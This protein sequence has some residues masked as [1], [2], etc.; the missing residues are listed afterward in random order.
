MQGY[1]VLVRRELPS[2]YA[3]IYAVHAAAFDN[4]DLAGSPPPE[5][6][7]VDVLR[8]GG[9]LLNPLCLVALHDGEVV[10]HVACS[11]ATVGTKEQPVVALG[12]IG[13]LPSVQ[14]RGVG[15]ALMH[16][17]L[18]AADA[19]DEPAVVLLGHTDYY[20]QFGFEPAEPHGVIP[21]VARW[22]AH[23]QIR[24][25]S[26]WDGSISGVFRFAPPFDDV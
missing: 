20:P 19:L 21:P 25:L 26:A 14:Q 10:G 22:G 23:F 15:K 4:P 17:A 6:G 2:D 16:A 18:A 24:R 11:R 1:G 3:A 9:Y 12:P 5:A 7:L 13:V 8:S